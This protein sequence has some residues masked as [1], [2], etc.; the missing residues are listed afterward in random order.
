MNVVYPN[1]T[2][3]MYINNVNYD[4]DRHQTEMILD[5]GVDFLVL[6][7]EEAQSMQPR[8]RNKVYSCCRITYPDGSCHIVVDMKTWAASRFTETYGW[9]MMNIKRPR[10]F[11]GYYA[12]KLFSVSVTDSVYCKFS[13]I[14]LGQPIHHPWI[15]IDS[16]VQDPE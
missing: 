11:K 2:S 3:N 8:G 12:E 13:A 1:G 5:L 15:R 6:K 14:P 9:V 10:G 4:L 16:A 7:S